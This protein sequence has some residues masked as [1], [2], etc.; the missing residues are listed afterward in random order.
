MFEK[1]LSLLPYNPGMASQMAFYSR[2]M[3]EEANIRRTAMV[4]LILA[5][6]VQF[7]AVLSPPQPTL[8]ATNNNLIVE[9]ISSAA[10]AKDKCMRDIHGYMKIMHYYGI[11]CGDIGN[12]TWTTIHS[13]AQ[14]YYSVGHNPSYSA[15]EKEAHIDG[16]GT[17]YWRHITIW[18]QS[19]WRVLRIKN[20]EGKTFYIIKDCG[21]LVS[22]GVPHHS[23]LSPTVPEQPS[24]S[25]TPTPPSAPAPVPVPTTTVI[26]CAYNA[27]LPASSP[28]CFQPCQY[29]ASI[30]AS[31]DSCKPCDKSADQQDTVACVEVSKTAAN[32]TAGIADANNTTA[33]AG[34][35][36]IYTLFAKNNGKATVKGF[37]FQENLNDVL[38]YAN[39]SDFHG[40]TIDN[41]T[42]VVT[43]PQRD[44]APN[45]TAS[46]QI[47]VKVKDPIPTTPAPA[48]D[49]SRF[50]HT[51]SNVYGNTINIKLP[52]TPVTNVTTASAKLPNTGPGTGLALAAVIVIVGGYFYGRA[53]LLAGESA[54]A[55]KDAAAA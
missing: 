24:P 55:L 2:R 14:N 1:L 15:G 13:T 28:L 33:H 44:I 40:G 21:N 49:P 46:V 9:G 53:R 8:A 16:A 35:V 11:S 30:P 5:F 37:T 23:Q 12:G 31:D 17:L 54:A 22:V 38:D 51:M 19:S 7:V 45:A 6:G 4:F 3:R 48:I 50:D 27:S 26:P 18:G 42:G 43:W 47:T 29:N 41:D 10:D 36:I 39:V 34:D 32:I 52:G 20:N 25:P